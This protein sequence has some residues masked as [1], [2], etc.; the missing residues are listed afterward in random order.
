MMTDDCGC[1]VK[2]HEPHF[3]QPLPLSGIRCR[4]CG[5]SAEGL[6]FSHGKKLLHGSSKVNGFDGPLPLTA[7]TVR[8]ST[9][10]SARSPAHITSCCVGASSTR[11]KCDCKGGTV[12][13]R[14]QS[15]GSPASEKCLGPQISYFS[16]GRAGSCASCSF[17]E[18]SN[19]RAPGLEATQRGGP[20]ASGSSGTSADISCARHFNSSFAACTWLRASAPKC[21][22]SS[23]S[24]CNLSGCRSNTS[25]FHARFT[26]SSS[27][28]GSTPRSSSGDAALRMRAISEAAS[29]QIPIRLLLLLSV[30]WC[31]GGGDAGGTLVAAARSGTCPAFAAL[32][33]GALP[34]ALPLLGLEAR[35]EDTSANAVDATNCFTRCFLWLHSGASASFLVRRAFG[36]DSASISSAAMVFSSTSSLWRRMAF[37]VVPSSR[38]AAISF[39]SFSQR[40]A[41]VRGVVWTSVCVADVGCA[42]FFAQRAT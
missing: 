22:V 1:T 25:C 14:T 24:L 33:R 20:A 5:Q 6:P 38:F 29:A 36:F 16:T 9:G 27:A 31:C 37:R 3:V 17:Q 19:F 34:L 39:S 40:C 8:G 15:N 32:S 10:S 4:H 18:I 35:C 12:A 13:S 21:R 23:S 26:V 41:F 11:T 30:V 42:R 28:D 7:W 2:P